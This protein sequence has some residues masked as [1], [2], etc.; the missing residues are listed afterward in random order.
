MVTPL[1]PWTKSLQ[2]VYE[3]G[4]ERWDLLAIK[5]EGEIFKDKVRPS[6]GEQLQKI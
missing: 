3:P 6:C 2:L 1:S 5:V 4:S